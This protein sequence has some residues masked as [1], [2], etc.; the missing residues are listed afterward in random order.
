MENRRQYNPNSTNKPFNRNKFQQRPNERYSNDRTDRTFQPR[1]GGYPKKEGGFQPRSGDKFQSREGGYQKREGGYQRREG[2]YQKREGGYQKRE[3][4]YQSRDNRFQSRP[5]NR[6]D[7]R[8]RFDP[9]AKPNPDWKKVSL[10]KVYSEMQVTDGKHRGKFFETTASPKVRP[11]TRRLRE[12]M[13]KIISRRVRARRFLDLCAGSGAVGLEA[14][15][16]GALLGT[17]V[18]RSAKMC[19]FIRKNMTAMGVKEG[20]GE[21]FEIEVV[22]F[23]KRM[24]K[25]KR[26]WDVV[27]LDPPY[28]TNYDEILEHFSRGVCL[29]RGGTLIIEHHAEMFFPEKIGVMKRWRVIVEGESALSFYERT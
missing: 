17:F 8:K 23:L 7:A 12:T 29:K 16:R 19:S 3:G 14:I 2:G 9:K 27:F 25:R 10:P 5:P 1:E 6:F 22:P 18:E 13:F 11:T 20:H 21:I 26:E 24:A 15:S 28:D 4:G